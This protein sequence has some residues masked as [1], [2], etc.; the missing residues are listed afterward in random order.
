MSEG[1]YGD[2]ETNLVNKVLVAKFQK[3]L[4]CHVCNGYYG[5][6]FEEQICQTC[7]LFLFS[8]DLSQ[9]LHEDVS[10]TMGIE[11]GDS[12]N[13]EPADT[14]YNG[15]QRP[16]QD[17][18]LDV[19]GNLAAAPSQDLARRLQLLSEMSAIRPFDGDSDY[20]QELPPEVLLTV[21]SYLDDFSLWCVS[22]VCTRWD[23]LLRSHIPQTTWCRLVDKCWPLFKPLKNVDDWHFICS[24]LINSS[25]CL[26]CVRRMFVRPYAECQEN[27]WRRR[28]LRHEVKSL[29]GDPP[30]GIRA[31]PL[32]SHWCHWQA[33]IL[34]PVGSPFEGGIFYLYIQIPYGYPMSPPVVRFLTKIFH[35]NISR[36]GDIGLDSIHHNWSL[37]LTLAKVLISI[38][39]LLTDPFCDV[40]MEPDIAHL[41]NNDRQTY[42][43][44]ARYWTHQ[45]AMNDILSWPS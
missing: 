3:P 17:I 38:Q 11:D 8:D 19:S 2:Q 9:A 15:H 5:S 7:H 37:A 24:S 13:D 18:S 6:C 21:F 31:V 35:P 40:C 32:D 12:G 26:S 10:N 16:I 36:H 4:N 23:Q 39:S 44:I 34:G 29:K 42:D 45:F 43:A 22:K 30:E 33:T 14:F 20:F 41:Y 25:S 27:S 28:R 1:V